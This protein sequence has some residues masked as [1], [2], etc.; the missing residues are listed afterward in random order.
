M[1]RVVQLTQALAEKTK[2]QFVL[3][4]FSD[5]VC[6]DD[7]K[8]NNKVT[9]LSRWCLHIPFVTCIVSWDESPSGHGGC[10]QWLPAAPCSNAL[11]CTWC[12]QDLEMR[13]ME[14]AHDKAEMA[15]LRA[16]LGSTK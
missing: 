5:C 2:V 13:D 3:P 8:D 6:T 7:N 4:I 9:T 16:E 12:F 14:R 11:G 15:R 1:E 10:P